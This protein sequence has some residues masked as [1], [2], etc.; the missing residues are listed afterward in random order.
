MVYWSAASFDIFAAAGATRKATTLTFNVATTGGQGILLDMVSPTNGSGGVLAALELTAANPAGVAN[1]TADVDLSTNNGASWTTIASN[2]AMDQHGRGSFN[3]TPSTETSGNT[4]LIRVRANTG[5]FPQDDSDAPFLITNSG[6]DYYV[7]DNASTNDLFTTALGNNFASGKLADQPMASL[8]ALLSAY[9]LDALDVIHVDTGSYRLYRN[10][11]LATQ[12]SGVRIEGPGALPA[13]QVLQAMATFNRNNANIGQYVFE[14]TGGDNVTLDHLAITTGS[15]GVYAATNGDSDGLSILNSDIF[16]NAGSSAYGVYIGT[17]NDDARV[18]GNRIHNNGGVS[19]SQTGV[20]FEAARALIEQNEVY[21]QTIGIN[22]FA[23]PAGVANLAIIRNNTVRDNSSVGI[24]GYGNTLVTGNTVFGNTAVNAVGIESTG[25]N[26]TQNIVY[27]NYDGIRSAVINVTVANNR[28]YQNSHWGIQ[29]SGTNNILGNNVYANAVG[30]QVASNA[31]IANNVLYANTNQGILVQSFSSAPSIINNTIYQIVGDAIRVQST[32]INV[33]V[34][35]NIVWVDSGYDIFVD[36]NSQTGFVSNNNLFHQSSDP[37]AHVGSWGGVIRDSLADWQAASVQDAASVAADPLFVD[38]DGADNV[39]GYRSSD[40]Y[41]GGR[42][43]NW[44]LR[45]GSPAI[46]RGDGTAAPTL[47]AAG[48]ARV[49]DPGTPNA[50]T[51]V[52]LAYVDLGAYEFQGSSLDTTP[53]QILSTNPAGVHDSAVVTPFGQLTLIFSE[54]IN[55]IDATATA[56]YELR[57]AGLN[58]TLGDGDDVIYSLVPSYT[59]GSA[60]LVLNVA[61]GPLTP[62][63]YRLTVYGSSGAALHDLAGVVLDGDNNGSAGGDYTRVF[64]VNIPPPLAGDYDLDG[65]VDRQDYAFWKS[66]FRA[67]AGVGLQADGNGNGIVDAADYTIWRNNLGATAGGGGSMLA[68]ESPASGPVAAPLAAAAANE[69][70]RSP[71]VSTFATFSTDVAAAESTMVERDPSRADL[72][73]S[74]P[75]V[76]SRVPIQPPHVLHARFRAADR[77][78]ERWTQRGREDLHTIRPRQVS[79]LPT[80]VDEL[81]AD[82]S[83]GEAAGELDAID[84]AWEELFNELTLPAFYRRSRR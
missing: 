11:L 55:P 58:G 71:L 1:P 7:N 28:V 51:P 14:T 40:G 61:V 42:D 25:G 23:I 64:G 74:I 31:L 72:L 63:T 49:D 56:N 13:G 26:I 21:G 18:I 73:A 83:A 10:V 2:V 3:W 38:R 35:N 43:D 15:V 81:A 20:Y 8:P 76:G 37:N 65:D 46:D 79:T 82:R 70:A 9:D 44:L 33:K 4:A 32:S 66:H 68:A 16:S 12:D 6:H 27:G 29:A 48:N 39:L 34:R 59:Q 36:P 80:I 62:G 47:D 24:R 5:S 41:D 78:L 60:S 45:A 30:I 75:T 17:G 54:A 84:S 57:G 50:G 19:S 77:V 22:T 67:T 53:P 69:P 52:G